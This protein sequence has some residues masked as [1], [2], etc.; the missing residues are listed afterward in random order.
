MTAIQ[1]A[2]RDI[3]DRAIAT[4][5]SA[6]RLGEEFTLEQALNEV[7]DERIQNAHDAR[8]RRGRWRHETASEEIEDALFAASVAHDVRDNTFRPSTGPV[9]DYVRGLLHP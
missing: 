2:A 8:T 5:A 7:I 4:W 1:E 6:D 3:A 9:G